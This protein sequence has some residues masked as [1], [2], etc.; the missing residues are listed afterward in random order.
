MRVHFLD[1]K[2]GYHLR[3][4]PFTQTSTG[5]GVQL[6]TTVAVGFEIPPE[7][8]YLLLYW[9]RLASSRAGVAAVNH[10]SRARRSMTYPR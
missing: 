8:Q 6:R 4:E 1:A 2:Q 9:W 10:Q 3:T 5:T 7:L